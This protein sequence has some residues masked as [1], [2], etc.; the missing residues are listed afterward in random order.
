MH[1]DF[2]SCYLSHSVDNIWYSFENIVV[3]AMKLFIPIKKHHS[4]QHPPWFNSDIRHCL[5]C[6]RTLRRK[7]RSSPS[8]NILNKISS[9]ESSLQSKILIAKREFESKLIGTSSTN[10][11]KIFKYLKT[12]TQSNDIPTTVCFESSTASTDFDKANLFNKYFYSVFHDPSNMP[13][14]DELPDISGSIQT[15][16]IT[17]SDVYEALMS[18]DINKSVGKDEI[19]PRVLQSCAQSLCAPLHY[20]FSMSLRYA[21][22]PSMW[23]VHKIV[24]IF[25]A[26]DSNTVSNYRPISLLSNVS[27]V[28]ERLIYNKI[29]NFVSKTI[30]PVQFGFTKQCSTLQQMLIFLNFII[31]SASQTDVIYFDLRKAFDTVSHSI[32]LRKLWFSGITGTLWTWFKNYLTDRHQQVSINN[33]YSN[34]LPV[35]SGVPQGSILGPL[36]FIMYINNITSFIHHCSLLKFA[37]DAKCYMHITNECDPTALQEDINSLVTWSETTD[38][39]FSV[40][41][42]IHLSFK[43]KVPTAYYMFDTV[44]SHQD[45]HK[46]LGIIVS[47]DLSWNKHYSFI[48]ARAYR[49]LGL[50]RRTITS[51][52]CPS[53]M[54]KL[55]ISLVRSQLLYCTQIWRPH[56]LKDCLNIERVQRR[57]TKY[58]L[59]DYSSNYKSRLLELKLLPLMYLFELQDILFAIK[60]IKSPTKQFTITDFISFNTANTRSG[61]SNKLIHQTHLNNISRHSYFHR[62]PNLWNALPIIDLD[63]SFQVI[64]SKL[65]KYLWNHFV[66]NFDDSNP[67]TLHYLCVCSSCHIK[68][69]PVTNF[70]HL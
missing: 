13:N 60:S 28:L 25:K 62:L 12:V 67:C 35:V 53:I 40:K 17:I 1:I 54:V 23:K 4:V 47:E 34:L 32:L 26:G 30:S 51:P 59:S 66:V 70:S 7:Q 8:I 36:L 3:N 65:K 31:N 19:S 44:I 49:I 64:K 45:S 56:L 6:L 39:N 68:K 27:K 18:L 21:S 10:S 16:V 50:I 37:D 48:I 63:Q 42:T 61:S 41:K 58:M 15:I 38:M 46:D 20:L 11:S 14:I 43:C 33:V 22:I 24:P 5:N 55:Y 69:P 57:A 9:L 52:H 29:I 2:T